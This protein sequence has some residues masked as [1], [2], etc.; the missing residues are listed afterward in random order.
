L[1]QSFEWQ[2]AIDAMEKFRKIDVPQSAIDKA[3]ADMYAKQGDYTQAL[4]YYQKAMARDSV[5]SSVYI[6]YAKT[7][8]DIK[9]YKEA[10]FFFALALRFDPLNPDA[11]IG[12]AKCIANTDSLDRAISFLQDELKKGSNARAELLSAIADF[13]LQ[14]GSVP[15]AEEF[16][17]QAM[18]ADQNYA[19]PYKI[20][21]KIYMT[22]ETEK[23]ML[24]KALD[25]Y[26]SFSDRNTSDP[27]GY[28]ERYRIF[29][30]KGEFEK[31]DE[32]LMKIYTIY[33]KYPNLHFYKGALYSI[34]GNQQKAVDEYSAELKNNPNNVATLIAL[35]KEL[36]KGGNPAQAMTYLNKAMELAPKNSEAKAEGAYTT[37]LLKNFPGSIALFNAAIRLDP[38]NALLYR[39]LGNTY[40]D[41]GDRINAQQAYR[42][43]LELYPDAPDRA[44]LQSF[45]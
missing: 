12:T 14:K 41:S 25:A 39:R 35:G 36:V 34:M 28:L 18:A 32:E 21:A 7:L 22:R 42:R 2:K 5:D 11:L 44:E 9:N 30:K 26:K 24:D 19:Y 45:R 15:Q 23:G 4:Q 40:R 37:Y 27:S 20:K 17:N 33:P 31:A 38:G 6:A 8:M 13:Y 29:I 43:Y 3:A 16:L 10:P 1:I